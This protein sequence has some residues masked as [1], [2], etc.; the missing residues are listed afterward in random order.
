MGRAQDSKRGIGV[1]VGA[2]EHPQPDN[3]LPRGERIGFMPVL[4]RLPIRR[5][6][7]WGWR[8]DLDPSLGSGSEVPPTVQDNT[9]DPY[10]SL[11]S[12][13]LTTSCLPLG[14]GFPELC[15]PNSSTIIADPLLQATLAGPVAATSCPV[16]FRPPVVLHPAS[17]ETIPAVAAHWFVS[18]SAV[19]IWRIRNP[20]KLS[21]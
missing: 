20:V 3:S 8:Q 19:A 13:Q 21:P 6:Q 16:L 1:G 4:T 5:E 18:S 11:A 9:V 15:P 14:A 7:S 12:P 10:I 2:E 17:C